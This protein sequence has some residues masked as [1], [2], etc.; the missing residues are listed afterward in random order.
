[1]AA[2][3]LDTVDKLEY[4]FYPVTN[5]A[6]HFKVRASNDAHVA[7][8]SGPAEADPMYEVFIGGWKNSKSVIRKNRT[9]PDVAEIDTPDILNDGEFRGFWI[10][11][12]ENTITVGKEG[13]VAA[14]LTY[15][16]SETIPI[17]HVGVCTGWG[18]AG[19][20]I[21]EASGAKAVAS[22]LL[23]SSPGSANWI[24]VAGGGQIPPTAIQGGNDNGEP[25]FIA[26]AS[27]EGGV[28]PGKVVQSHGCCYIAWGGAE[29]PKEEFEVLCNGNGHWVAVSGENVPDE[30]YAAGQSEDGETLYIGRVNHE[31]S[32]T[33]GKVQKSHGVC[34][35]PYGGQEVAFQDYEVFVLQ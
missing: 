20:W 6:V 27:H 10:R 26:R 16:D 5:N 34:Y 3:E 28:I 14:L 13:E 29:V 9:K 31:D 15:E 1:M 25:Q 18:A 17:T 24:P 19:S 12:M 2:I 11:W 21:I 30:A 8:T 4:N 23:A 32:V 7:L 35:I 22:P 33:L